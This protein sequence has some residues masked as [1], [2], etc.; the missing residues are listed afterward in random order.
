VAYVVAERWDKSKSELC[1]ELKS[2]L[3]QTLPD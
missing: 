1:E 2:H 3:K